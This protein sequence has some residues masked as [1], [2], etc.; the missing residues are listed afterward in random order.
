MNWRF[1]M[2]KWILYISSLLLSV[3]IIGMGALQDLEGENT[4]LSYRIEVT[5]SSCTNV[6]NNQTLLSGVYETYIY[7]GSTINII[8]AGVFVSLT[9]P[10]SSANN[11]FNGEELDNRS[12]INLYGTNGILNADFTGKT[13]QGKKNKLNA[14]KKSGIYSEWKTFTDTKLSG[15]NSTDQPQWIFEGLVEIGN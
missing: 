7:T 13:A 9:H 15:D 11:T 1:F 14:T 6:Y 8:D 2:L 12:S 10:M 4:I 5:F 3:K